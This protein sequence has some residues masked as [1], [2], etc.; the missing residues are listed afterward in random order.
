MQQLLSK[1]IFTTSAATGA[2]GSGAESFE[3]FGDDDLLDNCFGDHE[4][5]E[6]IDPVADPVAWTNAV[7]A[8]IEVGIQAKRVRGTSKITAV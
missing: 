6:E 7:A 4:L 5:S 8:R 1:P 2:A 3:G